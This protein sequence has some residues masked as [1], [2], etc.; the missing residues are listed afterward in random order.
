ME[1]VVSARRQYLQVFPSAAPSIFYIFYKSYR[2]KTFTIINFT[3]GASDKRLAK[4]TAGNFRM[5]AID[6]SHI[7]RWEE[8]G[9]KEIYA[10]LLG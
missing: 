4:R 3:V 2:N 9:W 8:M 7:E 10:M 5:A 1:G 6:S